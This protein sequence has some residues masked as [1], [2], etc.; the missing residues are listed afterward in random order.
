MDITQREREFSESPIRPLVLKYSIPAIIGMLVNA[1]YNVVDRY[2]IGQ[3][4][5]VDAMSGIGLTAPVS[6]ILL[7]FMMLVG[8]GAT[9]TIS[10]RLGERRKDDAERVLGNALTLSVLVGL[11]LSSVGLI[12][13]RPILFAFGASQATLPH[14]E[15]YIRII[16]YGN[17]FNTISFAMNHTIRG[18]GFPRRSAS[19]QLLGAVLNSVLDPLFIFGFGL[20]VAGAAIATVISQFVSMVWVLGFYVSGGGMVKLR[21]VNLRLDAAT[22][23]Q[24]ASIGVSPF[25]MQI[26][27]S[28]VMVLANRALREHG[29]DMAIGAM[30]VISSMTILI[31]MPVFGINQ[32]LQPIL[33]YNYGARHYERVKAVW[34]YGIQLATAIVVV[35]FLFIQLFPQT[36]IRLFI[37]NTELIQIGTSGM[38]L[39]LMML[40]MLGFQVI[41]TVYFSSVGKAKVSLFLSMLRQVILL[42]PLYLLLP[43]LFGLIGIWF[44]NPAADLTATV[45][46]AILI[47][48]EMKHLKGQI[49]IRDQADLVT[50]G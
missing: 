43:E 33:G 15:S 49:Q 31:M 26:A 29:G 18:G 6:N 13:I 48:R 24:I 1:L 14:A 21:R 35:G 30:T 32:G 39:Y 28:L 44:A 20:G 22:I 8:I 3:L 16:L 5:N 25:A 46:T 36:I 47:R 41:S 11:V 4:N 19:T 7:G 27:T 2:W 23:R 40:P 38:R 50:A 12:L 34:L 37:R 9:A 10:I 45:I 42:V 17:V